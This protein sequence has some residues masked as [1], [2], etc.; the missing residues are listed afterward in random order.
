MIYPLYEKTIIRIFYCPVCKMNYMERQSN[1]S[2]LVNHGPGT[3]CHVSDG[4]IVDNKKIEQVM[5]IFK[6]ENI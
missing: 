2:C 5:E 4:E 1:A 3:C 6:K